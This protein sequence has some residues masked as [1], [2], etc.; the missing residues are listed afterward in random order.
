M[1]RHVNL[2]H[3]VA[4][5]LVTACGRV[6][7]DPLR[8]AGLDS[9]PHQTIPDASYDAMVFDADASEAADAETDAPVDGGSDAWMP[10]ACADWDVAVTVCTP[11]PEDPTLFERNWELDCVSERR[12]LG[13]ACYAEWY[14]FTS[15][16]GAGMRETCDLGEAYTRCAAGDLEYQLRC[17]EFPGSCGR[18]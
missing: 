14:A 3:F 12:V 16:R 7:Y 5:V 6:G 18:L 9:G 17:C 11:P 15:C 4:M 1:L 13:E 8:D 10:D 2:T